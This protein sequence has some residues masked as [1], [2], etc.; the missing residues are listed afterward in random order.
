MKKTFLPLL[1][2]ISV[3]TLGAWN[4][5][6][7]RTTLDLLYV[8][9]EGGA[10]TLIVTPAGESILVDAGWPGFDGRDAG[11]IQAAMKKAGITEIDHLIVTHYHTDHYGGVPEL[12]RRVK[13]NHFYDHGPMPSLEE[14]RDFAAKYSA[15]QAASGGKSIQLR[16]G[17]AIKLRQA[18]GTPPVYLQCLAARTEPIPSKQMA[19]V[20]NKECAAA[21]PMADDPSD[22]AR[23]I[24]FV[25]R[26]GAFD[27]LD[28]GDLT[29]NIEQKLVCPQNLIGA[30]DLYQVAHHGMNISNNPVLLRTISPTVAIMNN[31]PRKGGHP[32]AV[33]WLRELPSLKD[34][35]AVH[36]NV[37]TS[38]EQNAAEEL[39]ANPDDKSDAAH[40]LRVSVDAGK[41]QFTVTN[42]RNGKSG[43]YPLK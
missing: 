21:K 20:P 9:V 26:Y 22:N 8:D 36:R 31:G 40:L 1:L 7:G 25:L 14:D 41:R 27:F 13:I 29:W 10:A 5:P 6:Q 43:T 28:S 17:S 30:I 35:W 23:S 34:L 4:A 39:I 18:P 33:K 24:V 38:P 3:T 42:D 16:A 2:L 37:A 12:A 19:G 32:D 11:R 15:Y